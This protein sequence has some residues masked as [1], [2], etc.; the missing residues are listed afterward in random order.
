MPGG[1]V[2]LRSAR[3]DYPRL[4]LD[5]PRPPEAL[6]W[7]G[8]AWP[9]AERAVA[10]VGSRSASDYGVEMAW[11]LAGDLARAGVTVVSGMARGVD[12]AAHEGALAVGGRTVA[13]LAVSPATAY[14]RSSSALHARLVAQGAVCSEFA[15]G[16]A[17]RPGLFLRRNRVVAGLARGV[18]VVEA[19]EKSGAL[20]TARWARR[21]RRFVAAVP[22]DVIR[23]GSRG[24]LGLLRAGAVA[25]GDAGH[26]LE[27]LERAAPDA[28]GEGLAARLLSALAAGPM[29][30]AGLAAGVGAGL[31]EVGAA[32]VMLE[33]AGAVE[34]QAGGRFMRHSKGEA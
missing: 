1:V 21:L 6:Y 11:R 17:P 24:T 16:T 15:D 30:P 3:A 9:P 23:D 34:R 19:G 27:L 22:G 20:T 7:C 2:L 5:L 10:V 33:L 8:A 18:V 25:V 28:P 13:V 26:V 31:D 14:P 29:T 12:A 4:L 32:L